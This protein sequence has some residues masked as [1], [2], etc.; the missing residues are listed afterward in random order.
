TVYAGTR[1]GG[2]FRTTDN[3]KTWKQ[4]I[5]PREVIGK[6]ITA[7]QMVGKTLFVGT[8]IEGLFVLE[9]ST[10]S[11]RNKGLTSTSIQSIMAS[12]GTLYAATGNGPAR[13]NDGG[14][15]CR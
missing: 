7:L 3:G 4:L 9:G 13:S 14:N 6:N 1:N 2:I 11:P 5:P 8:D 15:T 12:G 10:L